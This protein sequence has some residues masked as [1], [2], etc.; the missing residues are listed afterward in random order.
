MNTYTTDR[1]QRASIKSCSPY[2]EAQQAGQAPAAGPNC[3]SNYP[4]FADELIEFIAGRKQLDRLAGCL[5]PDSAT[6]RP[7]RPAE[8]ATDIWSLTG[9]AE[10]GV[11]GDFRLLREVG[12]GGMGIVYEA[13]Q[14]S[15]QRRVALKVL[16]FAAAFDPKQLQRFKHESLAAAHLHHTHIVP[17]YAV[18]TDP[19]G[20]HYYAMQ[21]IE[22][23][24]LAAVLLELRQE[25]RPPV[26]SL[27]PQPTIVFK[28]A[29][30]PVETMIAPPLGSLTTERSTN[31][32]SFF[33]HVAE[34]G[35][36]AAEALEHAHQLGVI[37]RDI[38][39]ANLLLD[40]RGHLWIT[41][42]GLA[43]FQDQGGLTVTGELLG[44]LR[45]MSPE[46]AAGRRAVIDHRTDIY[47]LGATLYELLTLQPVVDGEDRHELLARLALCQPKPPRAIDPSIP[48]ELETIV[49]KALAEQP[50]D[51]YATAQDFAADLRR[52][53]DDRPILAKRPSLLDRARK[54]GRRNKSVVVSAVVLLLLAVIGLSVS[55]ILI[56]G[57]YERALEQ[58]SKAEKNL[59]RAEKSFRQ[60]RKAVEFFTKV[61]KD[62][63][64]FH[65]P[66]PRRACAAGCCWW[67]WTISR[68][69]LRIG[70]TTRGFK[71][72]WPPAGPRCAPCWANCLPCTPAGSTC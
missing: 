45:Y 60:A 40:V 26:R 8:A 69:S 27:G 54:W 34:L 67:H 43:L 12:R 20:Y 68:S 36:K 57:A 21:F 28:P 65:R 24:S 44:T 7:P 17:V 1:E 39:P 49:L 38:K 51:R 22:G 50:G 25:A 13:E 16:P 59:Q 48:V 30:P 14:L 10:R 72:N 55:T 52:F 42:F 37:H 9:N 58:Q 15:L 19:C 33:S 64:A 5:R 3:W 31:R 71:K 11:I 18:G 2:I 35:L 56:A 41:D 23:Q 4:E 46:Q 70:A 62:E 53:L 6:A 61:S 29:A 63:L 32:R 47:S 66:L